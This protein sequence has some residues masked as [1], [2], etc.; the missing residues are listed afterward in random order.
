MRIQNTIFNLANSL[1]GRKFFLS[2]LGILAVAKMYEAQ[3]AELQ[4]VLLVAVDL[5]GEHQSRALSDV[6]YAGSNAFIYAVLSVA[7]IIGCGA[8]AQA[9]SDRGATLEGDAPT[10]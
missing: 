5:T 7:L 9:L 3:I 10:E 2:I 6:A 8:I 1:M 4:D